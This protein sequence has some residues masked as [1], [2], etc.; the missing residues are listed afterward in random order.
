[1]ARDLMLRMESGDLLGQ[2]CEVDGCQTTV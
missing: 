1:M 2:I